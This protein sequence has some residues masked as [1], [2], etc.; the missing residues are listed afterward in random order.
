MTNELENLQ[1]YIA[2][3]ML[4]VGS[5]MLR[6]K[7][8]EDIEKLGLDVYNPMDNKEINDKS[9]LNNNEGLAEKIVQQDLK[10]IIDSDVIVIEPQPFALGTMV[11]LGQIHGMKIM[12]N[13]ITNNIDKLKKRGMSDKD[14]LDVIYD[15]SGFINDKKVYPHYEDI[16]RV[17]GENATETGDRRSLGIN[18]YVYGVVLDLTGGKGFYDW[19]EILDEISCEKEVFDCFKNPD[20]KT[21]KTDKPINPYYDKDAMT[22]EQ[23]FEHLF[24]NMFDEGF[25]KALMAYTAYRILDERNEEKMKTMSTLE[26]A[27]VAELMKQMKQMIENRMKLDNVELK[28]VVDIYEEYKEEC[29]GFFLENVDNGKAS[30]PDF[31]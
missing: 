23:Q 17:K 13:S 26:K 28:A 21:D 11:E 9:K 16:R 6:T 3:D 7:E 5:Q 20:E 4:T 25:Q 12:S 8:R 30:L 27:I 14:I 10:G 18:Q 31:I 15:M 24:K 2:G 29:T 1:A 22:K 19:D